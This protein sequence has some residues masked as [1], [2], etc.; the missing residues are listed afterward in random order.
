LGFDAVLERS[1][2]FFGKLIRALFDSATMTLAGCP[3]LARTLQKIHALLL[4]GSVE[5]KEQFSEPLVCFELYTS[6]QP[7]ICRQVLGGGSS[8]P[9]RRLFRRFEIHPCADCA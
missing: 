4:R 9:H 7:G 5:R 8:G 1:L 6:N 3:S 2:S